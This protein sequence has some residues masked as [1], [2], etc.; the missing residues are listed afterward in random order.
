MPPPITTTC[1]CCFMALRRWKSGSCQAMKDQHRPI[2]PHRILVIETSHPLPKPHFGSRSELVR[3]QSL[4]GPQAVP[5]ARR[6]G[7]AEQTYLGLVGGEEADGD[8]S[9]GIKSVVLN[10]DRQ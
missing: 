7:E 3:H 4:N 8:R 5:V 9:C 1:A 6:N 10:D 2:Q